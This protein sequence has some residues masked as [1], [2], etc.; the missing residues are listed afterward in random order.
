VDRRPLADSALAESSYDVVLA[1]HS[2]YYVP[3]LV[4]ALTVARR[5]VAPGGALVVLHAPREELNELVDVLA[6]DQDQQFSEAVEQALADD[7][8]P[9]LRLRLDATLD[10]TAVDS[11]DE[12]AVLDFAVQARLPPILRSK[13]LDVLRE[14]ALSSPG[15]RVPHPVDAFVIGVQPGA[16]S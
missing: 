16:R 4:E 9:V 7:G 10:L 11:E 6:P 13:V 14:A 5:A 12:A 15:L 8:E 2:L 3:D 1:V